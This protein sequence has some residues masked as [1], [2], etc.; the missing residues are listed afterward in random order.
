ME[1]S[2]TEAPAVH[3]RRR[4]P[5]HD[6]HVTA[7]VRVPGQATLHARM[8]DL[9]LHGLGMNLSR[10]LPPPTRCEVQLALSIDRQIRNLRLQAAAVRSA[11]G[12]D[13]GQHH[14]GLRLVDT[15]PESLDLLERYL[16]LIR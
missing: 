13:S 15:P 10:E 6:L 3:E 8:T 2:A 5:R 1:T 9:S 4:A 12:A 11:D 16:G 7:I 14:V